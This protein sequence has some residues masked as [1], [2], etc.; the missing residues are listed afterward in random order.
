MLVAAAIV[1]PTALL[2]PGAGGAEEVLVPERLAAVE[3]VRAV[4]DAQPIVIAVVVPG[5]GPVRVG[6]MQPTLAAA[7]IDD[8]RLGWACRPT[9]G[10]GEVAPVDDVA[11][12]VGL[13]LL[14]QA[15]WRGPVELF[16]AGPSESALLRM[17]G[18]ELVRARRTGL[19][20]V[21]GLSTRHGPDGPLATD[22]R[23]APVDD[24]IA[25]DLGNLDRPAR[26]RLAGVPARLAST[27]AISAWGPWQVLLGAVTGDPV[28]MTTHAVG[29]PFG[30]GYVTVSWRWS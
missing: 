30:A 28:A 19:L 23:A 22:E 7:G 13:L 15:G 26:G 6:R 11:G 4:V 24:A 27:L 18:D 17:R 2:V 5:T 16:L 20:L 8:G 14:D 1:P 3:A 25:T 9:V 21:G 29:A 12:A 10:A